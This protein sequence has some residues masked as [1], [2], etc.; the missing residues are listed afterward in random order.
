MSAFGGKAD[1]D[2]PLQTQPM[3]RLRSSVT[4]PQLFLRPGVWRRV[5]CGSF[6]LA[7]R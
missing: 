2:Q 4:F 1:S 5:R 3:R 7:S 6:F